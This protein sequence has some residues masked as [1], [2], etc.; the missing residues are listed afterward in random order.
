MDSRAATEGGPYTAFVGAA[1]RGGPAVHDGWSS[2]FC[3]SPKSN[4]PA[5][6]IGGF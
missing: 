1:L 3:Q 2:S 6:E 4:R 5:A